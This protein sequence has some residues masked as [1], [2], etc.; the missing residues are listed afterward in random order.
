MN[1]FYGFLFLLD[2]RHARQARR[3]GVGAGL[4]RLCLGTFIPGILCGSSSVWIALGRTTGS[5]PRLDDE[6]DLDGFSMTEVR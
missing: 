2:L 1:G 5:T 6:D 3:W 4:V